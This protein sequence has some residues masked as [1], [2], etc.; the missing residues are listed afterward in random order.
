[1]PMDLWIC[2]NQIDSISN[3]L[4]VPKIHT[5]LKTKVY[6]ILTTVGNRTRPIDH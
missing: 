4:M 3:N 1:M 6:N 2:V 5:I